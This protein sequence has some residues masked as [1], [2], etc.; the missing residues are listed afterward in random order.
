MQNVTIRRVTNEFAYYVTDQNR[1]AL[2]RL[3]VAREGLMRRAIMS[4]SVKTRG[5]GGGGGGGGGHESQKIDER[6]SKL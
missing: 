5:G 2:M 1:G 4:K 6:E 3:T